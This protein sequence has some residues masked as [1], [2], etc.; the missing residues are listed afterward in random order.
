MSVEHEIAAPASRVWSVITDVDAWPTTIHGVVS[1][2]RLDGGS[3]FG[4]GTRW[5]ETRRILGKLGT[6]ER[7][8][9]AIDPG[10]WFTAETENRG[11]YYVTTYSVTPVGSGSRLTIEF[12]AFPAKSPGLFGRMVARLGLRSVRS[13]L[14]L[15]LVA[16][17]V[18][19]ERGPGRA[20]P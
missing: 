17:A 2:E 9:T 5:R 16:F 20:S 13:S 7:T 14:E 4:E 11:I 15:D 6:E 18:A 12:A 3:G 8:V 10:R 19:A 1:V